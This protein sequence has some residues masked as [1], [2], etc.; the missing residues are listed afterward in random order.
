MVVP[1][2]KLLRLTALVVLPLATVAGVL[3]AGAP[4][5]VGLIA[6]F[7]L[8]VTFDAIR[9]AGLL[10]HFCVS[11]PETIRLSNGRAGVIAVQ[12]GNETER[13]TRLR[14]GLGLPAEL[15]TP[16]E[17][18]D[19][20]LPDGAGLATID[21]PVT[22]QARGRHRIGAAYLEVL[23]PFGLW[24]VRRRFATRCEA[25]VY[26][27]LL[28][29]RQAV[30]A[31]FLNR[32]ANGAHAQRQVGRGREFEKLREYL[33]GD[34][35]DDIHW[36]A[37]AKRSHPVTK[38]F[39]IER[40]QEVYVL[41][42]ASRL[43]A[44]ESVSEAHGPA[45]PLRSAEIPAGTETAPAE[46]TLERCLK[47]ALL[48]GAAAERQ[49]DLFGVI[50][51]DDQVRSFVRARNG[52]AHF[53]ACRDALHALQARPVSPDFEEL[54]SFL[55]LRLRRRA[56]LIVLTSLDDPVLS[57]NFVRGVKLIARQHL[58]LVIQPRPPGAR[59][60]FGNPAVETIDD[61]Y[62]EF[63]GHL[64]WQNLRNLEQTLRRGGVGFRLADHGQLA[65]EAIRQYLDVKR[66]QIL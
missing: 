36:K 22:P 37:T 6:A 34:A 13:G 65:A 19:L 32:G 52:R 30:A 12:L 56:L 18:A 62:A 53:A 28:G 44:R 5:A 42:D 31:V 50:A 49:G 45:A 61:V 16:S 59:P 43:S 23:S 39:Q 2:A 17:T 21:W 46:T 26:P 11:L 25:R 38:V 14:M 58:V 27:D 35:V 47:A 57:E 54:C 55:R 10:D 41:V 3:P 63:G 60:L 48:L 15:T 66:R 29:E 24:E 8:L 20:Q 9:S 51:F 40:T 4:L 64:R 1:S 33:P 7:G